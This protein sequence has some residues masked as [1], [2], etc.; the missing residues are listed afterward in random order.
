MLSEFK[1]KVV[2][3]GIKSL[4]PLEKK[5]EIHRIADVIAKWIDRKA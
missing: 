3:S 4:I 1:M 5:L 2:N